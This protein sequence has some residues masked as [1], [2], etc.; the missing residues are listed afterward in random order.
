[1]KLNSVLKLKDVGRASAGVL[2]VE[3]KH[4]RGHRYSLELHLERNRMFTGV[5]LC[6]ACAL[7]LTLTSLAYAQ[8]S[9]LGSRYNLQPQLP[10]Q[11]A[12]PVPNSE[13]PST[14]EFENGNPFFG[15]LPQGTATPEELPLSLTA[16]I[17]P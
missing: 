1:M 17:T 6:L 7:F 8:S 11:S 15:S 3:E 16:A 2:V 9:T 4:K 10:R 12:A 5:R 14:S 13:V